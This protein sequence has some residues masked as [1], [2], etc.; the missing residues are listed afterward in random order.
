M[1]AVRVV[2]MGPPAAGKRRHSRRLVEHFDVEHVES[3]ALLRENRDVSTAHG[4]PCDYIERGELVP[5][6][7]VNELVRSAIADLDG[8]VL[9]G[10]PRTREQAEFLAGLTTLDVVVFLD[11]STEVAVE[12]LLGRRV[13]DRCGSTCHVT[14]E[15]PTTPGRCDDCGG[16]LT[17]RDDDTPEAVRTRVTEFREKTEPVVDSYRRQGVLEAVDAEDE[18]EAV[19]DRVREIVDGCR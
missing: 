2:I 14:F 19:A 7:V 4:R 18:F 8:F 3:G 6:P 1:T 10:Y 16:A 13:C 9:D 5:D 11:V 12:R 17:R 15:P